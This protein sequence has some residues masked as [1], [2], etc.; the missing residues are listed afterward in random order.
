MTRKA[1][2]RLLGFIAVSCVSALV[3][4]G[5][6]GFGSG[7][8]FPAGGYAVSVPA[9]W[10]GTTQAGDQVGG[11]E[12]TQVWTSHRGKSGYQVDLAN[13]T[14]EGAGDSWR[15][16]SASAA[17]VATLVSGTDPAT[18]DIRFHINSPIDGPSA[19]GILTVGL[20]ASL[21]EI[22]LLEHETMTGTISPDGSIGPVGGTI[23]KVQAAAQA[24]YKTVVVPESNRITR[25]AKTSSTVNLVDLGTSLGIT[26]VP[27]T[28]L[29]EAFK[30]L[31]GQ[32]LIP[33]PAG[34]G[35][36]RNTSDYSATRAQNISDLLQQ[37]AAL[38]SRFPPAEANALILET[39]NAV[40]GGELDLASGLARESLLAAR[41]TSTVAEIGPSAS[42]PVSESVALVSSRITAVL[43]RARENLQGVCSLKGLTDSQYASMPE[44]LLGITTAQATLQALQDALPS[45]T[46]SAESIRAT[47]ILSDQEVAVDDFFRLDRAQLMNVSGPL[48]ISSANPIQFLSNYTNFLA[49]SGEANMTYL[50]SVLRTSDSYD[51]HNLAAFNTA[52]PILTRL[53]ATTSEIASETQDL[54]TELKQ[55]AYGLSMYL[56]SSFLVSQAQVLRLY[57]SGIGSQGQLAENATSTAASI[58]QGLQ[59]VEQTARV[60]DAR[61]WDPSYAVAQARAGAAL[62]VNQI[63]ASSSTNNLSRG[64]QRLWAA[65]A[66]V[67]LMQAAPN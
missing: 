45:I 33:T 5:C 55:A 59:N 66:T 39:Q 25:D 53:R 48:E 56:N 60:V 22:P 35:V 14:S 44:M 42:R 31:T 57:D 4:V 46:T 61:G 8:Q 28:Q 67:F 32:E 23:A 36:P 27:V 47:Q 54:T 13:I 50:A 38:S 11:V 64:L 17:T 34:T 65:S 29:S 26:V 62:S 43:S 7:S 51:Q 58:A 24:G 52:Y 3:L 10:V 6:A 1:T 19:G 2:P 30:I 12:A 63:S 20:L 15:A 21:R 18:V 9:L 41:R 49:K 16:A 40:R 37:S